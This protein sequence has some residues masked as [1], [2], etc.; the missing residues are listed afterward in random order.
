MG[1]ELSAPSEPGFVL[2]CHCYYPSRRG[3]KRIYSSETGDGF[4][5]WL[6]MKKKRMPNGRVPEHLL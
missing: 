4:P 5:A 6:V 3:T 2:A 1:E